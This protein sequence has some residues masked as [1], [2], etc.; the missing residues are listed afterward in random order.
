MHL[1]PY[2]QEIADAILDSVWHRRGL[3]FSVEIARQGGKN[4]LSARLE[5][6]CLS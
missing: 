1:R 5:M 6:L 3:T 2:Q 4:E